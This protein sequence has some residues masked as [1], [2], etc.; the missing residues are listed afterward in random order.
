MLRDDMTR[1]LGDLD[2]L[3]AGLGV[4]GDRARP[5][6]DELRGLAR[7]YEDALQGLARDLHEATSQ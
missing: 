6:L 3:V 2:Q 5:M 4:M 7:D 1:V